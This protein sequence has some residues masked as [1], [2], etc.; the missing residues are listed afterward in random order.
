MPD[1]DLAGFLTAPA[2]W[3]VELM[4]E[5]FP[6]SVQPWPIVLPWAICLAACVGLGVYSRKKRQH[7]ASIVCF[8]I[9]AWLMVTPVMMGLAWWRGFQ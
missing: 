1:F 3:F 4:V 7:W 8:L 2:L 9:A 6:P 5:T